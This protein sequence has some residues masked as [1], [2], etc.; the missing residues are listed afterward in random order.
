MGIDRE[1]QLLNR[2]LT[3]GE[4]S[5]AEARAFIRWLLLPEDEVDKEEN[6]GENGIFVG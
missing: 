2:M 4:L 6:E 1:W 3:G 5:P